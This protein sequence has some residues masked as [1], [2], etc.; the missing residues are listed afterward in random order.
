MTF[1][2]SDYLITEKMKRPESKKGSENTC[3]HKILTF[4]FLRPM[5]SQFAFMSHKIVDLATFFI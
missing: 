1:S 2:F 3:F 4:M 5:I